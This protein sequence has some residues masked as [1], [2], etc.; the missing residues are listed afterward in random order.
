MIRLRLKTSGHVLDF[1]LRRKG[2]E[3]PINEPAR[4]MFELVAVVE[5]AA[6]RVIKMKKKTR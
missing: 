2:M 1:V 3:R 4:A 6:T 5:I